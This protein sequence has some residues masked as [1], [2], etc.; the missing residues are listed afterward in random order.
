[1][2]D[3]KV[4][5]A[6]QYKP[7]I[8]KFPAFDGGY[9]ILMVHHISAQSQM[10][11]LSP[12]ELQLANYRCRGLA[13]PVTYSTSPISIWEQ[14]KRSFGIEPVPDHIP[15]WVFTEAGS[16]DVASPCREGRRMVL[17]GRVHLTL[18]REPTL[19]NI[20]ASPT[21]RAVERQEE[22]MALHNDIFG[23]IPRPRVRLPALAPLLAWDLKS[24]QSMTLEAR[25]PK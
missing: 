10:R 5:F 15:I 1:M 17:G 8:G 12:E 22:E 18:K 2:E 4:T 11:N 23:R 14:Y 21:D 20:I 16:T 3:R 24:T 13:G 6:G 19:Q 25:L 9:E 7:T